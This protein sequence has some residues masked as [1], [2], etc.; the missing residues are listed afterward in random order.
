M[1]IRDS[2]MLSYLVQRRPVGDGGTSAYDA[3]DISRNVPVQLG[4]GIWRPQFHEGA[5]HGLPGAADLRRRAGLVVTRPR[6][7]QLDLFRCELLPA[8]SCLPRNGREVEVMKFDHWPP[9]GLEH[10]PHQY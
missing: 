9:A 3:R 8:I 6:Q 2:L 10:G 1:C 7:G 5:L 4:G